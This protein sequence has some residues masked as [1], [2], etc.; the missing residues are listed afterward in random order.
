MEII[1]SLDMFIVQDE[2]VYSTA[3]D[4]FPYMHVWL[5]NVIVRGHL[6]VS[7]FWLSEQVHLASISLHECFF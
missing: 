6:H 5:M 1:A 3:K 2:G 7:V 4:L